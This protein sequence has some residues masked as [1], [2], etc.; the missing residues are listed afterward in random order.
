[1]TLIDI[2]D[3]LF[4][5]GLGELPVF[6]SRLRGLY[7][8]NMVY[9]KGRIFFKDKGFLR[10]VDTPPELPDWNQH[11]LGMV[12]YRRLLQWESLSFY[13]LDYCKLNEPVAEDRIRF[14]K[15]VINDEGER[16]YDFVGSI[17]RACH[18][19][20]DNGLLPV[21][22]L[23]PMQSEGSGAGLA[24]ADL[25]AL[26]PDGD[27]HEEIGEIIRTAI[28]KQTTLDLDDVTTDEVD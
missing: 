8:G 13:G 12:C 4:K 27:R 26:F 17:Y 10:D 21:V 3:S 11:L 20:L 22:L 14:L 18:L 6:Y 9:V 16:L 19:M 7:L 28:Q 24:I 15:S 23:Q 25:R 2:I 1:M 5:Q